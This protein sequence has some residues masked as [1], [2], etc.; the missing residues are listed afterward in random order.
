MNAGNNISKESARN[1]F[2][3]RSNKYNRSSNW[4]DDQHL[5]NKMYTMSDAK[6]SE[7]VLDIAIGT[8]KIA[9]AF[10]GKAGYVVGLDICTDMVN[11]A[12]E[13]VNALILSKAE[14][15]GFSDNS[16]DVCVCRQG[17]Q[18]ME[19]DKV[20]PEIYRVLKPSG[21]V[22]L[23]HLTAYGETDKDI[24]FCV[25]R[26][27]NPARRNFFLPDDFPGLLK[28]NNFVNIETCEYITKESV[29]KWI[30][31]GAISKEEMDKIRNS[32]SDSVNEFR[33]IHHV[34]FAGDDIL[35]SMMMI[36]VKAEKA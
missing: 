6:S 30:D 4:V 9:K 32:Y 19:L 10:Y 12:R 5:I 11:Q 1:H 17:L 3:K 34:E 22:V 8:G 16:F 7:R 14:Q 24:A 35:D 27:R 18:F 2:I 33:K 29:N 20:L 13:H 15:I 31:N 21:R 25:Q 23:C 26:L 28:T 36:I